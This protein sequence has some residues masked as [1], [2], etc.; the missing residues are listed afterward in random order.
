[1]YLSQEDF[2]AGEISEQ[3]KLN[4]INRIRYDP[5]LSILVTLFGLFF[6]VCFIY[7]GILI[8]PV[9]TNFNLILTQIPSE[10]NFYHNIV[11]QHN[12]TLVKLEN[13]LLIIVNSHTLKNIEETI[14]QVD[15]ITKNLNV[16]QIQDDLKQIVSILERLI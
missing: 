12:Q 13:N 1:M 3:T 4:P 7:A 9:L 14:Q 10:I 11:A 6:V 2:N 8:I 5:L 16:T 15:M